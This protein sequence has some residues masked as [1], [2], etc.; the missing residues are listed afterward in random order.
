MMEERM[1]KVILFLIVA[2]CVSSCTM[3]PN[4]KK[5]ALTIKLPASFHEAGIDWTSINPS[6]EIAHGQWWEMFNDEVLNALMLKLNQHNLSI[7][8]AQSAY[9]QAQAFIDKSKVA[10]LPVINSN[11][12]LSKSKTTPR[13]FQYASNAN[14]TASWELDLWGN[15]ARSIEQNIANADIAALNVEAIKLSSQASLAQYYFQARMLELNQVSLDKIVKISED[16]LAY[17]KNR[18]HNELLNDAE[19]AQI[20]MQLDNAIINS[21]DNHI[22]LRQYIHAIAVLIGE[23]ASDFNLAHLT[24]KF[25]TEIKIPLQIPSNVLEKRTDVASAERAVA[26]QNAQIGITKSAFFPSFSLKGNLGYKQSAIKRLMKL[27][28]AVWS[29]G[30]ELALNVTNLLAY[31]PAMKYAKEGYDQ[32]VAN[33]RNTVLTALQ[34][35][36]DQLV[37]LRQLAVELKIQEQMQVKAKR[38]LQV[39]DNQYQAGIVDQLAANNALISYVQKEQNLVN[40]QGNKI[41]GAIGLI[42]AIGGKW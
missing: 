32:A 38:Y 37:N 23:S 16:I 36:E 29:V 1:F 42:K 3:G 15:V 13:H 39:I 5:P 2:S 27:P 17:T 7:K 30:P 25:Y 9:N 31:K 8:A 34:D 20:S 6:D 35:V 41:L 11:Y 33:Y 4:Y 28:N 26:V 14:F 18:Y 22:N 21:A 19:L 24:Q 12:S 40:Y 10:L